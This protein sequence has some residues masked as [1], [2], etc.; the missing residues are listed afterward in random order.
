MKA[1][2]LLWDTE[3]EFSEAME[4]VFR[5]IK[6]IFDVNNYLQLADEAIDDAEDLDCAEDR[7][8]AFVS[9]CSFAHVWR[10]YAKLWKTNRAIYRPYAVCS[11]VLCFAFGGVL[12]YEQKKN[13]ISLALGSGC[14]QKEGKTLFAGYTEAERSGSQRRAKL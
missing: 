14:R 11:I 8:Q 2:N 6:D 9:P 3:E 7:R 4:A 13:R 12:C 1:D 5:L 10:S